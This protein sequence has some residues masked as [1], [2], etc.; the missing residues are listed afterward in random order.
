MKP[1]IVAICAIVAF[2][3]G[4]GSALAQVSDCAHISTEGQAKCQPPGQAMYVVNDRTNGKVEVTGRVT[5]VLDRSPGITTSTDQVLTL[6]PGER[7]ELGCLI[8]SP[9]TRTMWDLLDCRPL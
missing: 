9:K 1:R 8:Y 5:V 2:A 7:R 3:T 4:G 6:A